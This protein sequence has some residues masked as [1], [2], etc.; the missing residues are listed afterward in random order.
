MSREPEY[1]TG[2]RKPVPAAG[3][4]PNDAFSQEAAKN[5]KPPLGTGLTETVDDGQKRAAEEFKQSRKP[6]PRDKESSTGRGD[7]DHPTRD[8]RETP[9]PN[10]NGGSTKGD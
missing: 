8:T 7:P 3:P 6:R 2:A 10:P 9:A 5:R 1:H 4:D